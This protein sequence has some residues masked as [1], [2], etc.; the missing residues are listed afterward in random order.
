MPG[1]I[2]KGC[3]LIENSALSGKDSGWLMQGN[4]YRF[5][6]GVQK[7][8]DLAIDRCERATDTVDYTKARYSAHYE[9]GTMYETGEGVDQDYTKAFENNNHSAHQLNPDVQ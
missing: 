4:C 9:L 6:H 1:D 2:Q 7:N 8:L 5:G 3:S